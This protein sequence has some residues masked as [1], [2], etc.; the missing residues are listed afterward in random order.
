M[1]GIIKRQHTDMK[2]GKKTTIHI[3]RRFIEQATKNVQKNNAK[4]EAK[5]P[6]NNCTKCGCRK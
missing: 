6:A 1:N 5:N 3:H 2:M 4:N